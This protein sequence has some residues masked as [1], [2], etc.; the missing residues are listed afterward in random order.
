MLLA[1]VYSGTLVLLQSRAGIRLVGWI[2]GGGQRGRAVIRL[3]SRGFWWRWWYGGAHFSIILVSIFVYSGQFSALLAQNVQPDL[4]GG[5]GGDV[6]ISIWSVLITGRS[7]E[8]VIVS[9][10]IYQYK[11][12]CTQ[13]QHL[14]EYIEIDDPRI[15]FK[16][17]NNTI[18]QWHNYGNI[19]CLIDSNSYRVMRI[20]WDLIYSYT[21]IAHKQLF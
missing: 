21:I 3:R 17:W 13:L 11:D 10:P 6:Q 15:A 5:P 16:H 8:F 12:N 19:L 18:N 4:G 1:S 7:N 9:I 2:W 20:V 14:F